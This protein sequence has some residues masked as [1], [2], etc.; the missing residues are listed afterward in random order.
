MNATPPK[1]R[2]SLAQDVDNNDDGSSAGSSSGYES[3]FQILLA[4]CET[5]VNISS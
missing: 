4:I 2:S 5:N 3:R 1:D